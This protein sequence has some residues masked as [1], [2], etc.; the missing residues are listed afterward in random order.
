[1]RNKII[2]ILLAFSTTFNPVSAQLAKQTAFTA[3]S[4]F[5]STTFILDSLGYF[6]RE[7]GCEGRSSI[8]YGKY[9]IHKDSVLFYFESFEKLPA[10]LK[11]NN[12]KGSSDTICTITFLT[13]NGAPVPNNH[14]KIDAI[15]S[16]G[17]F[18]KEYKIDDKGSVRLNCNQYKELRLWYLEKIYNKK[19]R[20]PL[21]NG[22]TIIVLGLPKL[23]FYYPNPQVENGEN[24]SLILKEDGLYALDK[25]EKIFSSTD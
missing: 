21:Q 1:M 19:I 6:F 24:F 12:S 7:G 10:I 5:C 25:K 20:I 8:S 15:D 22:N 3:K 4:G 9:K 14:F 13:R 17:K 11:K 23:F 2:F 18:F 16:S